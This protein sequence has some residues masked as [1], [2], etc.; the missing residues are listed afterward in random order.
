MK[1]SLSRI[2]L[3]T[4]N[5]DKTINSKDYFADDNDNIDIQNLR[6]N[7]LRRE[8]LK[9]LANQATITST[10]EY[11]RKCAYHHHHHHHHD[12]MNIKNILSR[13]DATL[14]QIMILYNSSNSNDGSDGYKSIVKTSDII[15]IR[16]NR[17]ICMNREIYIHDWVIST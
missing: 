16:T 11:V 5:I 9:T 17:C 2:S 3:S 8:C 15:S 10:A 14:S 4:K 12:N 7:E 6:F 13:F 1:R